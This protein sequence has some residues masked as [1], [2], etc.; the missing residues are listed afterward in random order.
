MAKK[1]L[2][3]TEDYARET[4][5]AYLSKE[6]MAEIEE[7]ARHPDR[8]CVRRIGLAFLT[9]SK[10]QLMEGMDTAGAEAL[11]H[12]FDA[13]HAYREHLQSI[14]GIMESVEVRM[15]VVLHSALQVNPDL[16]NVEMD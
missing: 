1:K 7:A 3:Q 16:A 5:D 9:R 14:I 10:D 11:M 8:G 15:M 2:A 4:F 6:Q 13:V 12:A